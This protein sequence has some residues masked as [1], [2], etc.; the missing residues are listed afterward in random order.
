MPT[1]QGS[2]YQSIAPPGASCAA[3]EDQ[4]ACKELTSD[5]IVSEE[6]WVKTYCLL[7]I[8]GVDEASAR[9]KWQKGFPKSSLTRAGCMFEP[10]S[11][12][13]S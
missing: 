1:D 11:G 2:Y 3:W 9:A 4:L 13:S 10:S 6:Y 5:F 12:L 8:V 7:R